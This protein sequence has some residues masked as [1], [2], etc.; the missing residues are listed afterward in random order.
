MTITEALTDPAI[1][2]PSFAGD[3]WDA[4]AA[5]LSACFGLPLSQSQLET[6]RACT[7]RVDAPAAPCKE[8]WCVAGRRGGKSRVSALIAVYLACFRDYRSVLATGEV[9]TLPIVAAD[10]RQARTVMGYVQ[11]LLED[12]P[13]LTALVEHWTDESVLLSTGVRIE[14]HTASWRALRGYTV[15]GS[16]CDEVCFWRTEDA[17]N[18]DTEIITA[19]RPAMATVPSAVLVAITTPYSRHGIV[20]DTFKKH[21]GPQGDPRILVWSAPSRVMNPSLPESVVTDALELDEPAARAEYL[22]EWRRDIEQFLSR[23]LV[24][25]AVVKGVLGVPP[26][27]DVAYTAFVDPSGG[28]NDSF[29]IAVAHAEPQRDGQPI[30]VLD[31]VSERRPPFDAEQTVKEFAAVLQRY[32]VGIVTGDRYAGE[33]PAQA[34]GRH[35]IAYVPSERSKSELYLEVLPMFSSGR[36]RLLDHLRLLAQLCGLERR[37]A[38]SGRDSVDH[39]PGANQHDDLANACAGALVTA[40][41]GAA[42]DFEVLA[43]NV[44]P[45][46]RQPLLDRSELEAMRRLVDGGGW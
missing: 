19:L 5:F 8:A 41:T 2:G 21:H 25:D 45:A 9:G 17:V 11:G 33:W 34:F 13:M 31:L 29:T 16:V 42:G 28:S 3:T 24:E 36:V 26:R 37:T 23:E 18:A 7:G 22:A 35:G 10:R 44:A 40:A 43:A 1:F 46:D 15:V 12:S 4:W 20:W 6:F 39:G 30:V 27:L 38:R 14:I 32:R